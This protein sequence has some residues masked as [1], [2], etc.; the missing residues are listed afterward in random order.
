MA[1][2]SLEEDAE[3]VGVTN[4]PGT[5]YLLV[6]TPLNGALTL[7]SLSSTSICLNLALLFKNLFLYSSYSSALTAPVSYTHLTLPT[8]A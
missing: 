4:A 3:V 6:I 5:A 2:P 1:P 7:V 8:K